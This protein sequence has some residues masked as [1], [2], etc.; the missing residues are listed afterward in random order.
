MESLD[1]G[2]E[3]SWNYKAKKKKKK[4]ITQLVIF[5]EMLHSKN[6]IKTTLFSFILFIKLWG[7][8]TREEK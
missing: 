8:N 6:N 2:G 1:G 5:D 7:I 4:R 3:E